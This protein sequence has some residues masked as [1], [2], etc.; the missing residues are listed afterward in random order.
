MS[1]EKCRLKARKFR[2]GWLIW[3]A[4]FKQGFI[5]EVPFELAP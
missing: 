5:V 4:E 3:L 1:K 2:K